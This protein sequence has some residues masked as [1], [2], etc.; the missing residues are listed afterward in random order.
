LDEVSFSEETAVPTEAG[1]VT[2]S[3]GRQNETPVTANASSMSVTEEAE[4]EG[5]PKNIGGTSDSMDESKG[6]SEIRK[7]CS[8]RGVLSSEGKVRTD[9]IGGGSECSSGFGSGGRPPDGEDFEFDPG[10]SEEL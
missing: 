7:D 3:E 9:D 2:E 10:A 1:N 5:N 4:F 6:T 8:Y